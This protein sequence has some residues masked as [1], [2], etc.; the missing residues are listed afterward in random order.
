MSTRV[1]VI[2]LPEQVAVLPHGICRAVHCGGQTKAL[3]LWHSP[4]ESIGVE[5]GVTIGGTVLRLALQVWPAPSVSG[6]VHCRRV[7]RGEFLEFM[8]I[9]ESGR[10][11]WVLQIK[12]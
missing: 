12:H 1:W 6:A 8:S 11:L 2:E 7:S 3:S 5:S 10:L 4:P 9:A